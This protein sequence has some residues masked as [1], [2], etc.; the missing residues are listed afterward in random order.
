LLTLPPLFFLPQVAQEF[1]SCS[2]SSIFLLTPFCSMILPF[3][4][5]PLL[6]TYLALAP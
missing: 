3:L 4:T 1:F 5:L 6:Y 2:P